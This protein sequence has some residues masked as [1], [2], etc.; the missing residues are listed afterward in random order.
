MGA[1]PELAGSTVRERIFREATGG[2]DG[3]RSLAAVLL[4]LATF[5]LVAAV[6]AWQVT[7]ETTAVPML[8]S[9]I[10]VLVDIDAFL[11]EEGDAIR[12]A[13]AEEDG[14]LSLEQYPL[15]I[16]LDAGEVR[17][18]SD[19]ELRD[20]L[21]DRSAALVYAEGLG[22]FDRT[23][24]QAISR[25]SL[26]GMLELA[27]GQLSQETHE[28]AGLAAMVLAT[29]VAVLGAATAAM[30]SGWGRLRV[31]AGA[32][33]LGAVPAAAIAFVLRLGT[34]VVGGED[35]FL[36][37]TRAII[38]A[39]LGAGVRNGAIVAGAGLALVLASVA[40]ETAERRLR[41]AGET[42]EDG[43]TGSAEFE[44]V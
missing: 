41:P 22:A 32:V 43:N 20:M 2:A 35:Q 42:D 3:R 16:A 26:E 29:A 39:A 27:V 19:A 44:Q 30:I 5:G 8:R 24:S 23:G 25:V 15:P 6:S 9:G 11:A 1:G 28:R 40:L 4:A 33:A 7:A 34:E 31:P 12:Q 36:N 18:A 38:G 21:L 17:D 14:V 10:A 37:D 13:A